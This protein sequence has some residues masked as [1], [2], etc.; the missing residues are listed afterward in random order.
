MRK[1]CLGPARPT[2]CKAC[3]KKVGVPYWSVI[4][5]LPFILSIVSA[6]FAE[7]I[8]AKLGVVAVGFLAMSAIHMWWV[9]LQRR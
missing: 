5:V 7:P 6:A 4:A 2:T 8:L 9:P 1:F 3:G